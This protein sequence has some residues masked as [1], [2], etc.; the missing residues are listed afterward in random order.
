MQTERRTFGYGIMH[1]MILADLP[2]LFLRIALTIF[3]LLWG[4]FLNV[5]VYRVPRGM[6]VAKPAS[7]CPVCKQPIRPWNN[8]PVVSY[9]IQGGKAR[10]CGAK[11][12]PRYV[13][14]ELIGG[15][16]SLA[17][18][19]TFLLPM[20]GYTPL[21]RAM[22]VYFAWFFVAMILVA[23]AFIDL[24]HMFIP[25]SFSIAG[26]V[27]GLGTYSMRGQH[28]M[29]LVVS[30]LASFLFVWLVLGVLYE[31]L[32]GKQAMGLG[33]AY[34]F[35]LIGSWSSWPAVI[36]CLFAAATQQ[37]LFI[38]ALKLSGREL[39][40]PAGVVEYLDDLKKAAAEGDQEA[41]EL[42]AE[43]PLTKDSGTGTLGRYL[44]FGPFLVLAFFEYSFGL[45][46]WFLPYAALVTA[47]VR[48]EAVPIE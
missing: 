14:V 42:L 10:C 17:I 48:G 43:D 30:A 16:L 32:R 22:M 35:A 26:A 8:I 24:E 28:L 45:D 3:G 31:K 27:L 41:A 2:P 12:S 21:L 33:D 13:M 1:P 36:F 37:V 4:S 5:V 23:I 40:L 18:V 46:R 7:H 47:L 11:M 15:A 38:I 34:L 9:L 29:P 39:A 20:P 44:P 19:D 6:N 25:R